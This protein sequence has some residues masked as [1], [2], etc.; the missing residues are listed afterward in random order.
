[1]A[2]IAARKPVL[3]VPGNFYFRCH[4]IWND[5]VKNLSSIE[6]RSL[7]LIYLS[8]PPIVILPWLLVSFI[9]AWS[10]LFFAENSWSKRSFL[11]IKCADDVANGCDKLSDDS[12]PVFPWPE[13]TKLICE[14]VIY[15]E[16]VCFLTDRLIAPVDITGSLLTDNPVVGRV[17]RVTVGDRNFSRFPLIPFFSV[18]FSSSSSFLLHDRHYYLLDVDDDDDDQQI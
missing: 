16:D 3:D 8:R 9:R 7:I 14:L 15:V 5:K 2:M 17:I 18:S 11:F 6:W 13:F 4:R 10:L 1:M 12:W